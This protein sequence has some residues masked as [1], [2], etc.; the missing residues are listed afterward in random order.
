MPLHLKPS[1]SSGKS[2]TTDF[3]FN[4]DIEEMTK[5]LQ[6]MVCEPLCVNQWIFSWQLCLY[7]DIVTDL[8]MANML[9]Y[10]IALLK[11]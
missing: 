4:D 9:C 2:S 3:F 10:Q 5:K 6:L 1:A 7:C 11:L 8:I